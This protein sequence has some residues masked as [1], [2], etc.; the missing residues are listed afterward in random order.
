MACYGCEVCFLKRKK[1]K[2]LSSLETIYLRWVKPA[3]IEKHPRG[4][5]LWTKSARVSRLQKISNPIIRS[6]MQVEQPILDRIRRRQL[7]LY[8]HFLRMEDIGW[9]KQSYQRTPYGR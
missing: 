5:S 7:K 1:Q 2:K 9:P 3:H 4:H 8:R 6:E